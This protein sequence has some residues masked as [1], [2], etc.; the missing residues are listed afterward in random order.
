MKPKSSTL[1]YTQYFAESLIAEAERDDKIVAIHAGMEEGTRFNLFHKCFP[2]RCF[3]VEIA[4]QDV[5]TFAAG[6]ATKGLKPFCTI[7]SSF[8]R[9]VYYQ[10]LH[11]VDLPKLPVRFA[12]D[13]A[14][15]VGADG[16]T[17]CNAFDTTLLACLPNMVVM[18]PSCERE[19]MNMV[20]TAATI[21]DRSS[22]FRYPRGNGIGS[23]IPSFNKRTPLEVIIGPFSLIYY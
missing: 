16:L 6:L 9:R 3:D 11:D 15:V 18:E 1:S 5:V 23:I 8:L 12:I 13:S 21:D 19:L 10:L 2:D 14:G 7:Y 17:H 22:C 4:E 20:A